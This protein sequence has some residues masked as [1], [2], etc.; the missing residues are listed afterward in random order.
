M[1]AGCSQGVKNASNTMTKS[2][3]NIKTSGGKVTAKGATGV[4]L[5][6]KDNFEREEFTDKT[7]KACEIT[8]IICI[9]VCI[10]CYAMMVIFM[11]LLPKIRAKKAATPNDGQ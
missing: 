11:Y 6:Y 1:G 7:H 10:V 4:T 2:A 9:V 8:S 3:R 5:T